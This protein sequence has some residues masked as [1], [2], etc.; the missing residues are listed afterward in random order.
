[1]TEATSLVFKPVLT[2]K[3]IRDNGGKVT[4]KTVC[5]ACSNAR[6]RVSSA[7]FYYEYD[8]QSRH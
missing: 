7:P 6:A 4:R 8:R 5:E 3:D 1:M 2:P